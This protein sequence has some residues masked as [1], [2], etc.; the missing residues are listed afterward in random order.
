[1]NYFITRLALTYVNF[2]EVQRYFNIS[3]E[4]STL[5]I[6][7]QDIESP[8]NQQIKKMLDRSLWR[9][10]YYLPYNVDA[11]NSGSKTRSTI[12]S[13]AKK[14]NKI[15]DIFNFIKKLNEPINDEEKTEKVFIGDH[16]IA[17]MRHLVHQLKAQEVILVD[18][19]ARVYE[20][21]EKR[22]NEIREKTLV[23]LKRD[24]WKHTLASLFFGYKMQYL[25][26]Y[27]FF[28]SWEFPDNV[29]IKVYRNAY[30]FLRKNM[31]QLEKTSD[32]LLLGQPFIDRKRMLP[33][34]YLGYLE[35]IQEW[36]QGRK[37]LYKPHRGESPNV[38]EYIRKNTGFEIAEFFLPVEFHLTM[39]GPV[40]F[41]VG[42]FISTALQNCQILLEN[43]GHV[44]SFRVDINDIIWNREMVSSLYEYYT[45]IQSDVFSVVKLY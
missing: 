35:K 33:E 1:M 40:P 22:R 8:D 14:I 38:I 2:L 23:L 30:T 31:E 21:F 20:I 42:G 5:I 44:V 16:H 7:Y 10:I 24:Y 17:S 4:E 15:I 32:V 12:G 43:N 18:E 34:V 36:F 19:G 13:T 11:L 37:I 45:T 27:S 26:E 41:A 25:R 3:P 39:N 6:L 28:S 29:G 9:K